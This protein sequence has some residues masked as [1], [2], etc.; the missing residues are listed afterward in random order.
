VFVELRYALQ[1]S[2]HCKTEKS[3]NGIKSISLLALL[4]FSI[5]PTNPRFGRVAPFNAAISHQKPL[6]LRKLNPQ[7]ESGKFHYIVCCVRMTTFDGTG[8]TV[9]DL[10]S[11]GCKPNFA[12]STDSVEVLK[13]YGTRKG[14]N[15]KRRCRVSIRALQ[16]LEI[17]GSLLQTTVKV[18][19]L[20]S[21]ANSKRRKATTNLPKQD[22]FQ[23]LFCSRYAVD[24]VSVL[25]PRH[26][27]SCAERTSQTVRT[28]Q[29]AELHVTNRSQ[30]RRDCGLSLSPRS[31]EFICSSSVA[32]RTVQSV[33]FSKSH[34]HPRLT[35]KSPM[36][37]ASDARHHKITARHVKASELLSFTLYANE[38]EARLAEHILPIPKDRISCFVCKFV[39]SFAHYLEEQTRGDETESGVRTRTTDRSENN[40][41]RLLFVV[42][43]ASNLNQSLGRR[44]RVCLCA[45][46]RA[47][48]LME[49][50]NKT[51]GCTTIRWVVQRWWLK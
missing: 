46:G 51:R 27:I 9:S 15:C 38:C 29:E 8:N 33:S 12:V 11:T 6:F 22:V 14:L 19:P 17:A 16:D 25:F 35:S 42:T 26:V 45:G 34:I 47:D 39:R 28:R 5:W 21:N 49:D 32:R 13:G 37:I 10:V 7:F 23:L 1:T 18:L 2:F 40:S 41:I 44:R 4:N 31:S 30:G 20:P 24:V 43:S 3:S 48:E 36:E 50:S